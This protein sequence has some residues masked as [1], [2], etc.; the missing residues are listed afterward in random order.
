MKNLKFLFVLAFATIANAVF[1]QSAY[2][3]DPNLSFTGSGTAVLAVTGS[4]GYSV[5]MGSTHYGS[6][7]NAS[8]VTHVVNVELV[9]QDIYSSG[10][11]VHSSSCTLYIPSGCT[12]TVNYSVGGNNSYA[13]IENH[14]SSSGGSGTFILSAGT[15]S[16]CVRSASDIPD[17][18]GE[19]DLNININYP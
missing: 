7:A 17:E 15:Y 1:G 11:T 13:L 18:G 2:V 4:N 14:F 10:H 19:A 5:D 3:S 16:V 9:S 6:V 8:A 12:A